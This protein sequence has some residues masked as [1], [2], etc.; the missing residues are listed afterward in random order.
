MK[1][2][3]Q[4]IIGIDGRAEGLFFSPTNKSEVSRRSATLR[5]EHWQFHQNVKLVIY[6]R[7]LFAE[8]HYLCL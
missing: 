4:G 8:K 1:E 6:P 2:G 5:E 3:A 7:G